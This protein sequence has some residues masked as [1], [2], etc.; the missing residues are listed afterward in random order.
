[1]ELNGKRLDLG[2]GIYATCVFDPKFKS[3]IITVRFLTEYRKDLAAY[4]ALI[5]Q[6]LASTN[7]NY[8]DSASLARKLNSLYGSWT[9]AYCRHRGGIFELSVSVLYLCD[10]FSLN[11]EK[12]SDEAVKILSDCI[13]SPSLKDGGFESAEFDI[14]RLNLLSAIDSEI[15]D[16]ASY[17]VSLAA[18]TAY[19]GETSAGRYYGSR[20]DVE[21][22]NPVRAY[23]VYKEL[24]K[25]AR[26]EMTLSGGGE[27]HEKIASAFAKR[28]S[29]NRSYS[30]SPEYFA[31]SPLKPSPEYK[32][33]CLDVLQANLV[34]VFKTD[35]DK[36]A[37][38]TVFNSLYADSPIS[39]LFLNVRQKLSLCY[40]CYAVYS[41]A[42]GAVTVICGVDSE[43][44]D[45]AREEILS[46]LGAVSRGEFSDEEL[47]DIKRGIINDFR[48]VYD[49]AGKI[50]DWYYLQ[51][52]KGTNLRPEERI[53]DIENVT[54]DEVIAAAASL[55]ED[56][57]FVLK[58]AVG[59][60]G[61]AK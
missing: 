27:D 47:S 22:A 38:M 25:T 46:Q 55:R 59:G 37:A 13:F 4:Y 36:S 5:P 45:R 1:M 50:G 41:E 26:I 11:G 40:Y 57:V 58:N 12:I 33:L 44:V 31:K 53:E 10:R 52:I 21:K 43:N 7:S 24:L 60:N 28:F 34:M 9:G 51:A 56:T 54:R 39:K 3:D 6:M 23:E 42:K 16:K 29:E 30:G 35:F 61:D 2:A 18:E 48:S 20:D 8:P 15:N 32:Q 19:R 17:A 49:K 14:C